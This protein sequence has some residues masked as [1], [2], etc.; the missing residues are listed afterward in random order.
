[1]NVFRL[2]AFAVLMTI[3][4]AVAQDEEKKTELR[5]AVDRDGDTRDIHWVSRDPD[6]DMNDLAVGETRRISGESGKEVT[7]TRTDNGM[8]I[9]VDGETVVVPAMDKDATHMAFVS[10]DGELIGAGGEEVDVQVVNDDTRVVRIQPPDG[11]TIISSE[12][13]DDAVQESIRSVLISAGKDE[14]ITFLDRS[15]DGKRVKVIRK[16]VEITK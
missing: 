5:I 8:Q 7:L 2:A 16:R 3:G 6:F 9:E 13:L 1:M 12:P 15:A 10:A 14:E 11:I 4:T